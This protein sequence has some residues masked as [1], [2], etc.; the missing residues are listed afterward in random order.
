M[1]AMLLFAACQSYDDPDVAFKGNIDDGFLNSLARGESSISLT[2][3]DSRY[4]E[5]DYDNY[6][7]NSGKWEEP[8]EDLLG[9]GFRSKNLIITE[10]KS[11]SDVLLY[12]PS[13]LAPSLVA[14]PWEIYCQ[15]TKFDKKVYVACPVKYNATD[16]TLSIDDKTFTV[17]KASDTE[18][19]LSI[20]GLLY[21]S[22]VSTGKLEPSKASKNIL[23][24]E[25]A[26]I[27]TPDIDNAIYYDSNKNAKIAMV[28][29]M[30][31]YF[32]DVINLNL[33]QG[34]MLSYPIINLAQLEENP[35]NDVDEMENGTLSEDP[36]SSF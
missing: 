4:Y 1:L 36:D 14:Y 5:K 24:Y 16:K 18:L 29:M 22:N 34:S 31:E 12:N 19:I 10:G 35:R 2:E 15:K 7:H 3:T 20:T 17:E 25:K 21:K 6:R 33:Y 28:K 32:G 9:G 26:A 11:W 23:F 13:T 27:E 8:K 30:R